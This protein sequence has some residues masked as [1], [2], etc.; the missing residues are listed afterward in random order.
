MVN[1]LCTRDV[2]TAQRGETLEQAARRMRDFDVGDLVVV[3]NL[4]ERTPI[5]M[6]TDRDIVVGPVA[7]AL[8]RAGSLT[9]GDV[10]TSP[11]ITIHESDSLLFAM[12][13]MEHN[14]VRRLPVVDRAGSLTGVLAVDD[15]VGHVTAELGMLIS[16]QVTQQKRALR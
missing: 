16:V 10:M 4:E 3:N 13:K 9:L 7:Q 5:G 6:L 2:V 8:D 11:V 15:I 1:R 14:A 12:T